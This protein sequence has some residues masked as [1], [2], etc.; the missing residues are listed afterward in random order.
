MTGRTMHNTTRSTLLALR[1]HGSQTIQQLRQHIATLPAKT[2]GNIVQMGWALRDAAGV[3]TLTPKGRARVT[4]L[5]PQ[6]SGTDGDSPESNTLVAAAAEPASTGQMVSNGEIETAITQAL[7][8]AR[9]RIS[10]QDISRRT[11]LAE[12]MLRPTLT[13]MV[14]AGTVETTTT[15]PA[16]YR[17]AT[18][19][20]S[21]TQ[22]FASHRAWA[23]EGGPRS[24][25]N[26]RDYIAPELQ[27]NPGISAD[28]FTA[29]ALPSRVGNRLHWPDGRVTPLE[30]NTGLPV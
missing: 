12:H 17:L 16:L 26:S 9:V 19:R 3:Y 6:P 10:V 30:S 28:R 22:G 23:H 14:Q 15:K 27:R 24:Q 4:S 5:A 18:Q 11:R 21:V 20:R 7:S 1:A 13:T 8:R 29:Y 25:L 2:L